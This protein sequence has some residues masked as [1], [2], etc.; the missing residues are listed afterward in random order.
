LHYQSLIMAV[1]LFRRRE[2][3]LMDR[4]KRESASVDC[5]NAI[6]KDVRGMMGE[7]VKEPCMNQYIRERLPEMDGLLPPAPSPT[8]DTGSRHCQ[9]VLAEFAVLEELDWTLQSLID[10]D[11]SEIVKGYRERHDASRPAWVSDWGVKEAFM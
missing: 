10:G 5:A 4:F 11:A 7:M 9:E 1:F 2:P 8:I 3:L 6:L